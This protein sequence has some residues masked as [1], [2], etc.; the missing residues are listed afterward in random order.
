MTTLRL[1]V[2]LYVSLGALAF[3]AWSIR[4]WA[5]TQ[6][7][8]TNDGRVADWTSWLAW[9]V[10]RGLVWLGAL[11]LAGGVLGVVATA[12]YRALA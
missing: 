2:A 5:T 4:L 11:V 10:G 7:E 6:I 1:L 9:Q 8:K 12:V 3:S